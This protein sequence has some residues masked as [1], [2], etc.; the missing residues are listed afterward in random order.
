MTPLTALVSLV[1]DRLGP[2]VERLDFDG[3]Q[4]ARARV[5]PR[6][7]VVD[8]V[9]GGTDPSVGITF[10]TAPARDDNQRPGA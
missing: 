6:N 3:I 4:R 8:R 1:G 7:P 9:T 5:L 10:G 2:P